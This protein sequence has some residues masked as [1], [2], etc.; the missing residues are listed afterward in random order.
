M[1]I[2]WLFV[3]FLFG[4]TFG[5]FYNVVGLRVPKNIP[6]VNDH[7]HCPNC[8]HRLRWHE[9]IPVASFIWQK[10][11][12]RNCDIRISP[13]YPSM[14]LLTGLLFAYSYF[15]FG[16]Q[17][18]LITAILLIS[19]LVMI[20][21]S[22]IAYML[23][24]NK[25]LIFFLPLLIIMRIIVPLNPWYDMFIGAFLGFGLIAFIIF[26][27]KGGMGAGDMKLFFVLGIVLGWQQVLL[28]FF[29]AS[30]IGTIFGIFLKSLQKLKLRQPIPFGPSI[31][32]AAVISYFHGETLLELYLSL[33]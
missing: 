16:F 3:F 10:G 25:F 1:E 27:S 26:I 12:C 7:S 33:F 18:E 21:V 29:L 19:L 13:L 11:R 17:L 23:I 4:I 5:S 6:F 9:L 28:T 30:L 20:S 14:E 8:H 24:P 22:D 15:I 2:Y 32:A 31:A